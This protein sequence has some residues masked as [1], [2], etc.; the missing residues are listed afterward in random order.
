MFEGFVSSSV[1][2]GDASIFSRR[3][4]SG[5]PLLLLH[6]FPQ[7]HLMWHR[8]APLLAENFSVICADLRGYG[9]SSAPPSQPDHSPYSKRAMANDMIH[10]MKS[11][12]FDRFCVAGHDRGARVAY[13]LG[14]DHPQHVEQVAIL[15]VVPTIEA[16]DRA[17]ARFALAFWPWSLLAQPEPLPEQLIGGN[18]RA[19]VEHALSAWGSALAS[20]PADVQAA[21][22][23]AL[24][25][26]NKVHAICEEYR[27]TA[28]IDIEIER[29]DRDAGRRM[30]CPLLVLWA[31]GS[32]LDTWYET[33]G[34]PLAI[35]RS[36]AAAVDG[37][38]I[39]GGHFFAEENA[40]EVAAELQRFFT[41][42]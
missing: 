2:V 35:W 8:V 16:F 40:D 12:G 38:P 23:D 36:W 13:R 34:G 31:K 25:D 27:A 17:D 37:R 4:G 32:G 20:F 18:P 30:A 15:D 19:V 28:T 11:F 5:R 1:D 7:T 42:A 41:R 22:V 6:G 33:E 14:L 29:A 9:S 21:Y 3:K 24:R 10:L 39:S 26:P